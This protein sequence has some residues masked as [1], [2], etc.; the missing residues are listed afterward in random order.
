MSPPIGFIPWNKGIFFSLLFVTF[1]LPL[2]SAEIYKLWEPADL[3]LSI[4]DNGTIIGV[5]ANIT[6]RDPDK[7][8]IVAGKSMR[9]LVG[10]TDWNYTVPASSISKTGQYEY[11]VCSYSPTENR[12]DTF[13]FDVTPSGTVQTSILENPIL[14][15][16]GILGIIIVGIGIYQGNP[17]FGFVGSIMLLLGGIYTMIYGFNNEQNFY[18]Q[19]VALVFL[20]LGLI[21]MF[22]SAMEFI[23]NGGSGGG[24][25]D[26]D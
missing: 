7:T 26:E 22:V 21:F 2:A 17:W 16:F 9:N 3:R 8:V 1:L 5:T 20:G 4:S 12:C 25:D 24:E 23:W 18:T 6:V 11:T 13:F 14:L 15:L 19:G 10:T